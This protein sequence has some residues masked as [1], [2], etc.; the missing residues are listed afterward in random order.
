MNAGLFQA[1]DRQRRVLEADVDQSQ[2]LARILRIE[3]D[4]SGDIRPTKIVH[5]RGDIGSSIGRAGAP[6]NSHVEPRGLVVTFIQ[7]NEERRVRA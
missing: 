6:I 4:H 7:R 1:E 5:A 3:A 2:L